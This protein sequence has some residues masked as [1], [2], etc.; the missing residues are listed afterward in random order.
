MILN[1]LKPIDSVFYMDV[2]TTREDIVKELTEF[3]G[4]EPSDIVMAFGSDLKEKEETYKDE[5]ERLGVSVAYTDR[6]PE[7]MKIVSSSHYQK[8]AKENESSIMDL[9]NKEDRHML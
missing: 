6:D 5:W 8:I 4:V 9:E 2:D 7:K 3:Y 1:E